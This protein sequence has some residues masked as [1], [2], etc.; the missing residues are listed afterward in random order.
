M[1]PSEVTICEVGPRDGLQ[2]DDVVLPVEV[3]REL[4]ERLAATGL[5]RIEAAS[6]VNP[7]RVPAMAGAEE[8]IAG[9]DLD[10]EVLWTGLVLNERGFDRAA[11]SGLR[12]L[13]YSFGVTESFCQRNQGSSREDAEALGARIAARAA[14]AGIA[15]TVSLAVSFGCPFE[16]RVPPE[17]T[18]SAVEAAAGWGA[19]EIVLADTIGV[20]I[21]STISLLLG[22]ARQFATR[23]GAH[24]HDTR[25][26]GIANC[27]AALDQG[28]DLFDAS[29][30]GTG[31]CPFAPGA[32]GNVATEDLLYLLDEMGVRTGV[33]M[34]AIRDCSDWLGTV[35]GRQ[36]PGAVTRAGGFPAA[37]EVA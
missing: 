8:L 31:G 28:V 16:G 11:T 20:A 35:L 26:T 18:L 3:R 33:E 32:T 19:D 6:F 22:G 36:L 2:N 34:D 29:I 25:N 23:L 9:L 37:V 12:R 15:L 21:P 27:V 14:D 24:F 30:G 7:R 17:R 5:P 10:G 1:A 13:N 4:C